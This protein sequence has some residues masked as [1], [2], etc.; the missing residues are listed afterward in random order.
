[1]ARLVR[2]TSRMFLHARE[3]VLDDGKPRY[4]WLS[5][6]RMALSLEPP[7][8]I[9][10]FLVTPDFVV[11]FQVDSKSKKTFLDESQIFVFE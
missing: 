4:L 2:D 3:E 1:M 5:G 10:F 8:G 7:K 9:C 11:P 6:R